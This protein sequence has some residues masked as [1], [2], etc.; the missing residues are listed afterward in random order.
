MKC[1][2][3]QSYIQEL[4]LQ[5]E[6][7][8][9]IEQQFYQDLW[10]LDKNVSTYLFLNPCMTQYQ[11][12]SPDANERDRVVKQYAIDWLSKGNP[13]QWDKD[14]ES[15]FKIEEIIN[16][17]KKKPDKSAEK[18]SKVAEKRYNRY[19]K[20][21]DELFNLLKPLLGINPEVED[22]PILKGYISHV[23]FLNI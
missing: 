20:A 23:E 12:W 22:L 4:K 3:Y 16:G 13:K 10:K 19:N 8:G 17:W 15:E 21:L 9:L 7:E 11:D 5:K 2:L 14:P 18:I 1:H 6:L